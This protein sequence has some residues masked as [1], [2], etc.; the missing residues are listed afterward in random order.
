MALLEQEKKTDLK[1]P[2]NL[3]LLKVRLWII[4]EFR[5]GR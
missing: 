2:D 4:R 5:Y 3:S 1:L